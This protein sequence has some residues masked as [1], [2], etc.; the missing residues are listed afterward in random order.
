MITSDSVE[1]ALPAAPAGAGD[2]GCPA[3][4]TTVDLDVIAANARIV[5]DIAGTDMITVVKADGYGHG[6][7]PVARA[8]LAGGASELGVA[9]IKEGRALRAAGIDAHIT[10]WLHTNDADFADAIVDDLDIALSSTRQLEAVIAAARQVGRTATVTV[11][12]DTGLHRS[13]VAEREWADFAAALAAAS[14]EESVQLRGLMTHLACGDEPDHPLNTEQ[15]IRFD[16]AAVDLARLGIAPQVCHIANS[17]ATLTRPD[18][19]RDLVR[20]GI[21]IYGYSPVPDRG[22]FGLRP[23]MTLSAEVAL[24]KPVA[25][26]EGVSY[27]HAWIAPAD[28]VVAVL[29][30]GYADGVPRSLSGR[31]RV[32]IGDRIFDQVGRI[33]MDQL[34]VDLGA[35]GGGVTEGDRAVLFGAGTGGEQTATDWADLLGTIDYEIVTGMGGRSVRQYRGGGSHG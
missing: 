22:D 14:A 10:T 8:A 23:A 31:L 17:A 29:P 13:G 15:A 34:V 5:R 28:T 18:L 7:V 33:C 32:R 19:A 11:K 16:S 2:V 27:G 12:L 26:G 9:W 6:A 30:A 24:I 25:A 1:P 20:P 3:L 4:V 35:D 21:A